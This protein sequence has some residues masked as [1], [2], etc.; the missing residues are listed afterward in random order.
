MR[1]IKFRA[2]QKPSKTVLDM[3]CKPKM[4]YGTGFIKDPVNTWLISSDPT[5]A[6]AF[7]EKQQVVDPDT[8]GQFTG[9]RD[10]NG[11]EIYEGDIVEISY[12]CNGIEQAEKKEVHHDE[13]GCGYSPLNWGWACDGCECGLYINTIEVI[14][15]IHETPEPL[16]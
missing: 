5:Q 15:N 11:K 12:C 14:G 16:K 3:G 1:D 13:S 9:L 6:I 8:I 4:L 2:M 10:K 7:G